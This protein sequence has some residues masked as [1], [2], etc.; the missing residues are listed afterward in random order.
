MCMRG[1]PNKFRTAKLKEEKGRGKGVGKGKVD[2]KRTRT[3][4]AYLGEEQTQETEWW[5]EEDCIGWSKVK[6]AGRAF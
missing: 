5:L 1:N 6:K 2:F 3:G 4:K